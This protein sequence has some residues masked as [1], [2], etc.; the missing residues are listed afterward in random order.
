MRSGLLELFGNELG[1]GGV[2]LLE[3]DNKERK[4]TL[5]KKLEENWAG[6]L[7]VRRV[8]IN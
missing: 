4:L 6:S 8:G 7:K 1:L 3:C 5:K 2:G